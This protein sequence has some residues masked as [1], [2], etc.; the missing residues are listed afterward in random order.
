MNDH[1]AASGRRSQQER[2][3]YE[4]SC[5]LDGSISKQ[6][7]RKYLQ[8]GGRIEGRRSKLFC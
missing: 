8:H 4:R 2:L 1:E 3:S 5:S 7:K 6:G